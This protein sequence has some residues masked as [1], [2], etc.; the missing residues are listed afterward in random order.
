MVKCSFGS[1][2]GQGN[3]PLDS[4]GQ[5]GINTPITWFNCAYKMR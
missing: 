1:S 5:D 3:P 2:T 4:P